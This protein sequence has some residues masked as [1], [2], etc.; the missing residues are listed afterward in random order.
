MKNIL[1][2]FVLFL[3]THRIIADPV[4]PNDAKVI[5]ENFL[6]KYSFKNAIEIKETIIQNYNGEPSFY[7]FSFTEKGFVIIAADDSAYPILAYSFDGIAP[8]NVENPSTI[9]YF[10]RY[11]KQI[12]HIKKQKS[13]SP[14]IQKQWS[15]YKN[16]DFNTSLKSAGPL[17]T[18]I[19]NQSPYYDQFCPQRTP[20][21]CVATAMSQIMNYHQ[22]P[23]SGNGWHR[24][25]PSKNPGYGEQYAEFGATIYDWTNMPS[26]LDASSSSTEKTAVATLN[27]HAGVSVNM[28]YDQEGSGASSADVLFAL[29]SYF[30]YDPTTIQL[31]QFNVATT[32]EWLALI[33]N[34]I[35]YSRP[36]YYD[37]SSEADG[38]HA[39]VCD[40]YDDSNMLHINW[41]WGGSYNGYFLAT[42]MNPNDYFFDE[43]NSI[44]IGIQPGGDPQDMLWTKQASGFITKSRGVQFISPVNSRV[45]WAVANDGTT[46]NA[47]VKDFTVT[48]DGGANWISGTVNATGTLGYG[49]SMICAL[50]Q[51]TAWIPLYGPNGGGKIVKTSDAGKTWVTQASAS[52]SSPDGFPNVVHFWDFNNG[53]CMGDPNGGYFEIYTTTNGGETWNRVPQNNIPVNFSE[54]YG[55]VGYY[56]VYADIIWFSTNKGRI[57]KSVDKGNHWVAYQTP[58]SDTSFELSFKDENTGIIQ[59]RGDGN[60][61]IQYKTKNGGETWTELIPS[62]NFY[63]ASFSFVPN[64]NLL[65]STGSD[66]TNSFMGVSFSTDEGNTFNEYADFYKNFQFTAIGAKDENAI[67]AGGFNS[68]KYSDGMWHFGKINF[69]ANF[70]SNKTTANLNDSTIIF[71]DNSYGS[72]Q[73]WTW[74]FGDGASPQTETGKGPHKVK[75]TTTG[76]KNVTLTVTK[77]SEEHQLTKKDIVNIIFPLGI[78]QITG[79]SLKLYPNPSS[80]LFQLNTGKN[81]INARIQISDLNGKL[82]FDKE[83]NKNEK[84]IDISNQPKGVYLINILADGENYKGKIVIE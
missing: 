23:L 27:Y 19:W 46:N 56:A 8:R 32:T 15:N 69:A 48:T 68:D 12:D 30:K 21:G 33:K 38:G 70:S 39:W 66:Y 77:D 65:I 74:N 54:E 42:A 13:T 43:Y 22:W 7:I 72:P 25:T 36:V 35:D 83:L 49:A 18:T 52:F 24:Y 50:D 84:T 44:I 71:T 63:T 57:F 45:A 11:K 73:T 9:W 14:E 80:G 76:S 31:V 34:E 79:V 59:R 40:G 75:Y 5:A 60:N 16:G 4:S 62:G 6:K 51:N 1:L 67:W 10:E 37:G 28:D 29:T 41:G 26:Q 17:L 3:L 81:F 53:F 61:K 2:V 82:I 55:V 64:S 47:K 78:E 58:I 20:T